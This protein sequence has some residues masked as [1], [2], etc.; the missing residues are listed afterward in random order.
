VESR[1]VEVAPVPADGQPM[2][3]EGQTRAVVLIHGF[4][5]HL[6]SSTV[7]LAKFRDWQKR[8]SL[9]VKR[10]AKEADVY[11]FCYG[12]NVSLDEVIKHSRLGADIAVLRKV[13]YKEIVLIGHSAGGLVARQ[14]VEDNPDAGVT[15]VIQVCAPNAG[16][17]TALRRVHKNQQVFLDCLTEKN[18]KA[19]LEARAGKCI[20]RGVEFVCLLGNTDG[21]SDTDGV[22]PCSSQWSED[23]R[24]QGIPVVVLN[25][26]HRQPL[27]SERGAEIL[28]KLVREKQPRWTDAR[29]ASLVK[30]LFKE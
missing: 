7:P 22:V 18:R 13:G 27:R 28:T 15:K 25:V 6:R 2:R 3:S 9:A 11:A 19:C 5:M 12:Q 20:P 1:F 17:P 8:D 29:V 30:E 26:N 4:L 23:L 21:K 10:L 14:F 24:K 16:T